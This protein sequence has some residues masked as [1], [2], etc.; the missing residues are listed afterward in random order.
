MTANIPTTAQLG[1]LPHALDC[2]CFVVQ[3][4]PGGGFGPVSDQG[5][6]V[7]YM[8][9]GDAKLFFHISSKRSAEATD[10]SRFA[11]LLFES[12]L[13]MQQLFQNKSNGEKK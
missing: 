3:L 12:L 7:S 11:R 2:R 9:P 5:Y 6:G 1:W 13:E 10:S 4:C 8:L